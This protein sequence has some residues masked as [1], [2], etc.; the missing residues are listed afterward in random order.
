MALRPGRR[1]LLVETL[2]SVARATARGTADNDAYVQAAV[3][4]L[5]R[6]QDVS[7]DGGVAHSF[8]LTQ[9]WARSYPETTGY[10]IPTMLNYSRVYG[11]ASIRERA[12]RMADWLVKIQLDGGGIQ[13]GTISQ[14]TPVATIFNTGQ[15]LFGWASAYEETQKESYVQ[16]M[17]RAADWLLEMQDT[18]GAWRNGRS[19][20]VSYAI[21]TYNTRTAW[22]L[23]RTYEITGR[24][25]YREAALRNVRWALTQQTST[26][27]LELNCL[28]DRARPLTHTIAYAI[29]GILEVGASSEDE[30]FVQAARRAA[31]AL[32]V[33][34]RSDGS[35]A[36]R[37]SEHWSPE[38]SWSCLTGNVQTGII[39]GR[40]YQVCGGE[41]YLDAAR[42]TNRYVTSR[43]NLSSSEPGIRGGVS[44]S[45][46]IWGEYGKFQ[47]LS[48]AA[49][50]L[51]DSLMLENALGGKSQGHPVLT[52]NG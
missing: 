4:W 25:E 9:G 47:Y 13:A 32:L 8:S 10:I 20:H 44:G 35:L 16:A 45:W 2:R 38:V 49:K 1:L 14:H 27:W 48:W 11:D 42:K 41:R 34:Q 46:P 39:W 19:P 5:C 7:G 23:C 12:L 6:A 22:S 52:L 17:L 33:V 24:P 18:D 30:S 36:G 15:V 51:V 37:Y 28:S 50:F 43:V 3:S 26:G 31:D 29:R 21:N 40:L